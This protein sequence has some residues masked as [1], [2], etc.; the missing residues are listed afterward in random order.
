MY[1][2][3]ISPSYADMKELV[4]KKNDYTNALSKADELKEKRKKIL[5]EYEAIDPMDREKLDRILPSVTDNVDVVTNINLIAS[6]Y[7]MTARGV[8][9]TQP[10]TQDRVI[11]PDA[12]KANPYK[13]IKVV[14]SMSGPYADFTKFLRDLESNSRLFDVTSLTMKTKDEKFGIFDYSIEVSAYSLR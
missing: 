12:S 7:G 8:R 9:I 6:S 1:F 3:Y 4:I 2:M 11:I 5:A 10:Q 13:T 14:F